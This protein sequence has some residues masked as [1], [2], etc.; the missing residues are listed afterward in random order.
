MSEPQENECKNRTGHQ[1]HI[2]QLLSQGLQKEV[3]ARTTHPEFIC[4]NCNA[5]A[6]RAEY[7]CNSSALAKRG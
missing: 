4:H 7:L 3:A 6:D 2:C 1:Q 5:E